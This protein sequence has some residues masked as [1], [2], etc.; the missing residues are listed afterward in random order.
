MWLTV[1]EIGE[2]QQA[3]AASGGQSETLSWVSVLNFVPRGGGGGEGL[4]GEG[5]GEEGGAQ[6]NGVRCFMLV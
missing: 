3:A 1:R 6:G 4:G 5:E 2:Q